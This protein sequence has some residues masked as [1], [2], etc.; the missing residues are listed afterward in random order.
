MNSELGDISVSDLYDSKVRHGD[1]DED[2]DQRA[3]AVRFDQL[4]EKV[5]EKRLSRKT[6]SLGWLFAKRQPVEPVRGL[7][8]WGEVG[9]GK[10]M[11]MDLFF[12]VAPVKRKG[13][14]HFHEFMRNMHAR[15][16]QA[17]ADIASGKIKGDDPIKPVAD[18]LCQEMRLLCFDEFSVTDIADAMLLGR[19]FSRLFADGVV[20][21]AT[22]NV[23]PDLLYKDG[24]NRQLFL[25]FIALLK[26][27]CE[28]VRLSSRTDFRMEKLGG[29]PVYLFPKNAETEASFQSMWETVIEAPRAPSDAVE[30]QGRSIHVPEAYHGMARF[31]FE[32]LCVRPLGASDYL[33]LCEVY[34]TIFIDGI[35]PFERS[36]RNEAKRFI[37][38]IDTLYDNHVRVIALAKVSQFDL[39]Q[40]MNGTEAFEFDRTASR[41]TEM[42]SDEYLE[43]CSRL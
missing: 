2:A 10:T 8:I 25:P 5:S 14:Y 23:D 34:H 21:V 27:R 32:D 42:Q 11:I 15:I 37:I 22:S 4:L 33:R 16:K 26:E 31:S 29:Q 40:N 30:N 9:R 17:R 19:L 13:R 36:M 28:V 6:S 1:I 41:L 12:E 3:L 20:V 18:A 43:D 35:P 38:L 39:A 24:L 7:Y